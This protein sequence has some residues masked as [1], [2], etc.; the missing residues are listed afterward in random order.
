MFIPYSSK[1][2]ILDPE[3]LRIKNWRHELQRTFLTTGQVREEVRYTL[4]LIFP[5]SR[6]HRSW[7]DIP[8]CDEI[9]T[10]LEDYDEMTLEYLVFSKIGKVLRHIGNKSELPRQEEFRFQERAK[11]LVEHWERQSKIWSGD[12]AKG[13]NFTES[14]G[15]DANSP[16]LH[17]MIRAR[18]QFIGDAGGLK[19]VIIE[20]AAG[21]ATSVTLPYSQT[22]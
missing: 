17:D 13:S 22:R 6:A 8:A 5:P 19:E 16:I 21:R 4:C 20:N 7:K 18:G 3:A 9:F 11:A 15:T 10:H 14:D 2:G 1:H 12:Y